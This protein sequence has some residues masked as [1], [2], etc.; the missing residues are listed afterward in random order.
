MHTLNLGNIWLERSSFSKWKI[1]ASST[2]S[3]KNISMRDRN[4]VWVS[5]KLTI[6]TLNMLTQKI[7]IVSNELP[8]SPYLSSMMEI[9]V[10]WKD[11]ILL[12]YIN[13]LF[14]T[15]ILEG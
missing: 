12:E 6:L 9:V 11:K 15:S 14:F 13:N 5:Y 8:R 4:N 10:E 1:I 3:I 7:N 2:S